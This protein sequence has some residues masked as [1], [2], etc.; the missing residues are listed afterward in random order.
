MACWTRDR[1]AVLNALLR[2]NDRSVHVG[3]FMS[4]ITISCRMVI[5]PPG[6]ATPNCCGPTAALRRSFVKC[7]RE[8]VAS[9]HI[10][11]PHAIG[12][13]SPFS[14]ASG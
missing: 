3:L 4:A 5:A 2:S 10:I 12:R 8:V 11:D 9:L 6:R 1:L 7:T 14:L 13:I